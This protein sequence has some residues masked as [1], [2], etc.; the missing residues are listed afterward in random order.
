MKLLTERPIKIAIYQLL[1]HLV[2]ANKRQMLIERYPISIRPPAN[3][4]RH[5]RVQLLCSNDSVYRTERT[6]KDGE[7]INNSFVDALFSPTTAAQASKISR[8]R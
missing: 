6:E 2:A 4:L 8:V 7:K 1:D 3:V 5:R